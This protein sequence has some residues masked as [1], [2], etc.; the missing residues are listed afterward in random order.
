[1]T[2]LS[3]SFSRSTKTNWVTR[4]L[5]KRGKPCSQNCM[6]NFRTSMTWLRKNRTIKTITLMS[7]WLKER[8]SVRSW[9]RF[10]TILV[11]RR[12]PRMATTTKNLLRL[13]KKKL[14]RRLRLMAKLSNSEST[15][16]K[17]FK[18][19][20]IRSAL[21]SLRTQRA[22]LKHS[23]RSKV[24]VTTL[25]Q[26]WSSLTCLLTMETKLKSLTTNFL[27]IVMSRPLN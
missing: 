12:Y 5:I 11:I 21:S 13:S 4:W 26:N 19:A 2:T 23:K 22:N 24:K 8:P 10:L 6:P 15:R 7:C 14:M 18:L 3:H 20:L 27:K 25:R 17:R 16:R 9:R 1:M